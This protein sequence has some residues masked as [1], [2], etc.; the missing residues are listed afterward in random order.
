MKLSDKQQALLMFAAF[1]L[2]PVATWM[3]LGFPVGNVELGILGSSMVGGI[4]A[5]IKELLG[6]KPQESTGAA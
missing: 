2:P 1:V 5:G 4:I 6:G 3:G